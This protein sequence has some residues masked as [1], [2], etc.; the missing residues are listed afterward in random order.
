MQGGQLEEN[1]T[2]YHVDMNLIA[3]PLKLCLGISQSISTKYEGYG[4]DITSFT[5]SFQQKAARGNFLLAISA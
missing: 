4:L 2:I 1:G 5:Q 3:L